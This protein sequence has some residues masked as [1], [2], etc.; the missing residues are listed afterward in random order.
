MIKA[1]FR[2][3]KMIG[4]CPNEVQITKKNLVCLHSYDLDFLNGP[5]SRKTVLGKVSDLAVNRTYIFVLQSSSFSSSAQVPIEL[6]ITFAA[7]AT[8]LITCFQVMPNEV[9]IIWLDVDSVKPYELWL[10]PTLGFTPGTVGL[11]WAAREYGYEGGIFTEGDANM[12]EASLQ[13]EVVQSVA[14]ALKAEISQPTATLLNC[15]P[16]QSNPSNLKTEVSQS[17]AASLKCSPEQSVAANLKVEPVQLT[18]GQLITEPRQTDGTKLVST[19]VQP[20]GTLLNVSLATGLPSNVNIVSAVPLTI[21]QPVTVN[22]VTPLPITAPS[23]IS[24]TAS[25]NLAVEIKKQH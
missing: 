1:R 3:V 5:M 16:S 25:T 4:N 15:T 10:K 9:A 20:N 18:A 7:P 23:P 11:S 22:A 8:N 24:V 2:G 17:V 19:A 14:S 6:W 13:Q 12:Y 21:N